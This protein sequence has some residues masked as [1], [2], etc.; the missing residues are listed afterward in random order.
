MLTNAKEFLRRVLPDCSVAAGYYNVHWRSKTKDGKFFWG[1]RASQGIDPLLKTLEW[2]LKQPDI[3]DLYICMSAQGQAEKK[4]SKNGYEYLNAIRS[5]DNVTAL[6]SLFI[7]IDVKE[8]AYPDTRSALLALK[9]FMTKMQ[10]PNPTAIVGTGS[11]GIHVHWAVDTDMPVA[12]WQ[13]LSNALAKAARQHNLLC[14]AQCTIDS[15]R[16]LRIPGTFNNKTDV[17]R[18]VSLM[19]VDQQIPLQVMTTLLGAYVEQQIL[20]PRVSG[21]LV[22]NSELGKASTEVKPISLDSVGKVCG[23][24]RQGLETGGSNYTNPLWFLSVII[25]SFTTD[26][27]EGAHRISHGHAG[28]DPVKTDELYDR[29]METRARK[30]TGWPSCEKIELTGCNSCA[31][32]PLRVAKK[33]PLNFAIPIAANDV[34]IDDLPDGFFRNKDGVVFRRTVGD[35]GTPI[36]IMICSYPM[37]SGWLLSLIHISEPTRQVR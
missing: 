35:D 1:G 28:Y 20:P 31:T 25:A 5:Q 11:G 26:A 9:D 7:D 16:I 4:T 15:A 8:G 33:S 22:D 36:S 29:V 30:D 34:P 10:L 3:K 19:A 6:R 13:A 32:C 18:P 2:A 12:T 23:F 17:A 14:D 21:S 37:M 24:I 27:R